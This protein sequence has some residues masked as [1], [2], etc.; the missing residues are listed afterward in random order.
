MVKLQKLTQGHLEDYF[1]QMEA[2]KKAPL[3][4]TLVVV[5]HD[6]FGKLVLV[7][8]GSAPI[9]SAVK[10][11]AL[12]MEAAALRRPDKAGRLVRLALQS[13]WIV[14]A[15]A[16][17]EGRPDWVVTSPDEVRELSPAH[18]RWL[19]AELFG[20]W[21]KTDALAEVETVEAAKLAGWFFPD[22]EIGDVHAAFEAI[23]AAYM[24]A[25]AVS[26]N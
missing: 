19:A 3:D 16:R 24:Q 12:P 21:Q 25:V 13:G 10:E 14:Q 15:E 22:S 26:P 8:P 18:V 2:V 9:W 5:D 23:N 1:A 6:T 17:S 20:S 7:A 11:Y 4:E